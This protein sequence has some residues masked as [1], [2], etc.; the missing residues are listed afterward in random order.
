MSNESY[1]QGRSGGQ[2]PSGPEFN[3][4]WRGNQDY[5]KGLQPG[6]SGD[7]GPILGDDP[8]SESQW[9]K[10]PQPFNTDE[11]SGSEGGGSP[12]GFNV[13]SGC[14]V[15]LVM[16]VGAWLAGAWLTS[17]ALPH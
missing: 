2:P 8:N 12:S 11:N 15:L 5:L 13:D 6:G 10:P 4:W 14:A 7:P 17:G 3:E 1:D 9:P 16:V